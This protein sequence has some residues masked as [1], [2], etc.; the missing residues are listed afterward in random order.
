M[1][2]LNIGSLEL[3][4]ILIVAVIV[5]GRR[6]P[7]VARSVGKTISELRRGAYEIQDQLDV[8]IDI[9]SDDDDEK[10]Q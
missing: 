2:L 10:H 8:D 6:L 7:H 4:L 3:A 5:F 9:D 1:A